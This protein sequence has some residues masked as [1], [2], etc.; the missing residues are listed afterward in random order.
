MGGLDAHLARCPRAL[1][2]CPFHTTRFYETVTR[3]Q[4]AG[5][6]DEGQKVGE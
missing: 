3:V 2:P 6:P 5:M 1:V 4:T